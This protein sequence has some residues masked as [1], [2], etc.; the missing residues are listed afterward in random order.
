MHEAAPW[1]QEENVPA[2]GWGGENDCVRE[3]TDAFM[4]GLNDAGGK[5]KEIQKV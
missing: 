1:G 3:E 4:V 5:G 2:V